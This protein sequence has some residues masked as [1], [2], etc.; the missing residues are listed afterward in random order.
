MDYREIYSAVDQVY[1]AHTFEG[2]RKPLEDLAR[3]L[4]NELEADDPGRVC[5]Y[6]ELGG[7][8]RNAGLYALAEQNLNEAIRIAEHILS[9]DDP[10]YATSLN[11]LS[12]LYRMM[13]HFEEAESLLEKTCAIYRR[14]IGEDTVLYCSALNNLTLV[15]LQKQ[16]Y[17]KAESIS[18]KC[19][20]ILESLT[21]GEEEY[22][23]GIA[24]E[25]LAV[26]C[27]ALKKYEEADSC[28]KRSSEI[29]LDTQGPGAS[30]IPLMNGIAAN[31]A[32]Q[33]RYEEAIPYAERALS[34]AEQFSGAN[35]ALTA[36]CLFN[37]ATLNLKA[38]DTGQA[39]QQA[40]R[41]LRIREAIF[42]EAYPLSEECRELLR[43]IIS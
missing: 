8:Y 2:V 27:S 14:S 34:L 38:G 3:A 4:L 41:S 25:N 12:G 23:L 19:I 35:Q 39:E 30:Q 1:A 36:D 24:Y 40:L 17:V 26:S 11:N 16:D 22:V 18:R 28:Y 20:S 37:L 5:L 33:S 13:G 21:L 42:G 43:Q 15:N 9:E 6:N 32:N 31:L 29:L 7:Y 10:N